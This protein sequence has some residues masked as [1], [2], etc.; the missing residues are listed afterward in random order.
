M[1]MKELILEGKKSRSL[2]AGF[3]IFASVFFFVIFADVI[4]PH[5]YD[6]M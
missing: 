6:A 2:I 1:K 5:A 3:L 4:A